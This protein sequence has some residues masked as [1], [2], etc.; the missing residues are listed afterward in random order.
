MLKYIIMSLAFG[1]MQKSY[2]GLTIAI[3]MIPLFAII[4]YPLLPNI[5]HGQQQ[6]PLFPFLFTTNTIKDGINN[7]TQNE[8]MTSASGTSSS[9]TNKVVVLNFYD[10]DIGQLTNA[11][12]ILDKYGFKGTFF[13][14]CRWASSDNPERM[15]WQEINQLYREGHDIESHSTSHKVLNRLSVDDLDYEVG[16][17][18]Q[19]IHD[20]LG[21]YPTVF[22]PPHNVGWNNAT[23]IN[24]IAKYYD[25][26]IGGFVNDV[27]FLHCYGWKK[28]QQEHSSQRDCRPYSDNGTLNYAS[29]YDIKE[30]AGAQGHSNDT[31]IFDRFTRLVNRERILNSNNNNVTPLN[32]VL[33][34][35]YHDIDNNN[36][37]QTI[38]KDSTGVALFDKEMKYLHDNN[39]RVLTISD[40]GYDQNNKYLYVRNNK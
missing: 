13:I 2:F 35:G 31:L 26:S 5:A 12:T 14:V 36:N 16:Q 4:L 19:C 38:S 20:H 10:N 34:L 23:V 6:H 1:P 17:S 11:K 40:L 3:T 32:S 29:R 24:T 25:L 9:T 22:S 15:T 33:I 37:N 18:K 8:S 30:N 7:D 21:I 28:P 27:M 39:V